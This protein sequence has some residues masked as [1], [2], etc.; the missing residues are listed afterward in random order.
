MAWPTIPLDTD[1]DKIRSSQGVSQWI[2]MV[3]HSQDHRR[4]AVGRPEM[5]L[6]RGNRVFPPGVKLRSYSVCCPMKT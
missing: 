2:D 4:E 5:T 1:L 3:V 6:A